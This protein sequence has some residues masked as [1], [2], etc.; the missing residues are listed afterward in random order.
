MKSHPKIYIKNDQGEIVEAHAPVIISASRATD[1][2]AFYADWLFNRLEQGY[3]RWKNPFNGKDSYISFA[4]TRF[5][6]FWSKNPAPLIPH[7]SKLKEMGIKCYIQYTLNDYEAELL[8]PNVPNLQ[9]RVEAFKQLVNILG[10]GAVVWRFDPLILTDKIDIN[11]LIYKVKNVG[12]KLSGYTEKLIFSFADIGVYKNV[13]KNLD[14]SG[15]KYREWD[16]KEMKEFAERLAQ[17]NHESWN[18]ELA[19]CAEKINLSE[20]GISHNRCI[21]SDLIARL[22]RDD[23]VMQ[24][25][26]Y[27][28][29]RD[30][31]QRK[32]CGCILAKDIGAYNTCIH[33][34]A[35][36]YATRSKLTALNNFNKHNQHSYSD[37]II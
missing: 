27:S 36:C 19:T 18:Y 14:N 11:T 6:V 23:A 5:I 9:F 12:D 21:D 2:P 15:I 22:T 16:E 31:G 29:K 25:Y 26:L 28:T 7:L 1:I 4:N 33:G 35:Y 10:K 8:E 24:N 3:V 17:I 32:H 34:C 20:F 37:S 30:W 13:Y